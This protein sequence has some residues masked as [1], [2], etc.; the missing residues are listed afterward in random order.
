[1]LILRIRRLFIRAVKI[2]ECLLVGGAVDYGE[3]IG[4]GGGVSGSCRKA[5]TK[6]CD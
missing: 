4:E 5:T 3:W 2:E 1:M 6:D